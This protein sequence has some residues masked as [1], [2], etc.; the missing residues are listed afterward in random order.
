VT[1]L[2]VGYTVI[3]DRM[4]LTIEGVPPVSGS[5][6]PG[7]NDLTSTLS[8]GVIDRHTTPPGGVVKIVGSKNIVIRY[9][10]VIDGGDRDGI[11]F[12]NSWSGIGHCNCVAGNE[13][14]YEL[15]DGD[16]HKITN[17]RVFDNVNGIRLHKG[18]VDTM[19]TGN[20]TEA[21]SNHG[22]VLLD[23]ATERNMIGSNTT[24]ANGVDCIHLD[25]ADYNDVLANVSGGGSADMECGNTDI[26][27]QNDADH[28]EFNNNVDPGGN[29]VSVEFCSGPTL[30][31]NFGNNCP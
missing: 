15:E 19:I 1:G 29:L 10:V 2:C 11:E 3:N 14:G 5:C 25:E 30:N 27:V 13:Q 24:R 28:N 16:K 26:R 6:P 18:A 22:I 4:N 9:L 7:A 21:N 31:G 12:H 23:S 20:I 8:G 17:S